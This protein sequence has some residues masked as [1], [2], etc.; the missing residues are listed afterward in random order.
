MI[1]PSKQ[2]GLFLCSIG[3]IGAKNEIAWGTQAAETEVAGSR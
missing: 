3:K 2:C 1:V